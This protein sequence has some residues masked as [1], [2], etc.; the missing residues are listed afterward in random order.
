ML[1]TVVERANPSRAATAFEHHPTKPHTLVIAQTAPEFL[2]LNSITGSIL[3][4]MSAPSTVTALK[5]SPTALLAGCADGV[6]RMYDF[7]TGNRSDTDASEQSV[8]AHVGGVISVDVSNNS[9]L[10][11]GWNL[12]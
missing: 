7:R 3:R 8:L 5:S 9:A 2:F 4:S 6:L 1:K 11:I 12:R 10:T